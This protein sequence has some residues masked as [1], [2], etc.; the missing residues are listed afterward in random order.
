VIEQKHSIGLLLGFHLC[1]SS[2]YS[3]AFNKAKQPI[4]QAS[5]KIMTL[6]RLIQRATIL[7]GMALA[8]LPVHGN[9][10]QAEDVLACVIAGNGKTVCGTLKAVERAC[11]TTEA[12]STVCGKFKSAKKEGQEEARNPTPIAGY[13]KEVNKFVLTIEGC[14]KVDG[15]VRCQMKIFNKGEKRF[16][17]LT[18]YNSSLVDFKGKSY[19]GGYIDFGNGLNR[20]GRTELD[21]N[22]EII[23]SIIFEKVADRLAK[24]QLLNLDFQEPIKPVQFR[25]VI[26]S[27]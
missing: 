8:S 3:E 15:D 10:A 12:G 22:T 5:P 1:P 11:I 24:A 16:V 9:P 4:S 21:S 26:I 7:A 17:D 6:I 13:Q 14:R 18:A 19:V 23:I 20:V 27:N 2:Y 25:N